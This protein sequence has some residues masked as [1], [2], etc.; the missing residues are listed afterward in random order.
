LATALQP[1]VG[2]TQNLGLPKDIVTGDGVVAW[3][4]AHAAYG[5]VVAVD[6][7]LTAKER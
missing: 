7:D 5:R 6:A 1:R 2:A 3:S 4:A